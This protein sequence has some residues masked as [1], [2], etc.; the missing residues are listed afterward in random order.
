MGFARRHPF[1][2]DA[3]IAVLLCLFVLQ[4]VFGSSHYLT[5]SKTIYVPAALLMTLPLAFRRRAPLPV[6]LVV[7]AALAAQS[8]L[9]G[10]AKT[11]DSPL[12]AWLLAIYTM[13]SECE[14]PTALAGL[15]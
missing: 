8:I 6:A 3:A 11:P 9:V 12:P 14:R 4:D 5:A 1:G 2:T 13:A 10:D 7:A 15:A